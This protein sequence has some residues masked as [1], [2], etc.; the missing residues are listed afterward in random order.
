MSLLKYIRTVHCRDCQKCKDSD[1]LALAVDGLEA[2]DVAVVGGPV[3]G[4]P[5]RPVPQL[6]PR[7]VLQQRLRA[8]GVVRQRREHQR[9]PSELVPVD[10][11]RVE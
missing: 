8:L 3:H 1:L 2:V 5:A 9:R 6:R 7:A 10:G 4:G 11:V